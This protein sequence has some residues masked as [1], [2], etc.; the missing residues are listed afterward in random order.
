MSIAGLPSVQL[1]PD[2]WKVKH[3]S[4]WRAYARRRRVLLSLLTL[5]LSRRML[6]KPLVE[7]WVRA[8]APLRS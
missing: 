7:Q 1:N 6:K 3:L 2:F 5:L 4:C 8:D